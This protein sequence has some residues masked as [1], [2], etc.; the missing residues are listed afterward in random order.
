MQRTPSRHG[1]TL[2]EL[3]VV[4]SIIALLVA[5]LLP[6]L[7]Q[8]REAARGSVCM[9]NQ[10]QMLLA[11]HTMAADH[12]GH[13]MSCRP[14]WWGTIR[15]YTSPYSHTDTDPP[16]PEVHVCPTNARITEATVTPLDGIHTTYHYGRWADHNG[17]PFNQLTGNPRLLQVRLSD[18]ERPTD[19]PMFVEAGNMRSQV[20]SNWAKPNFHHAWEA[21]HL[22]WVH[23][24]RS[25]NLAM[26]DG[27]VE[28]SQLGNF[29]DWW[30]LYRDWE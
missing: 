28:R 25:M 16:S 2:V 13:L 30:G 29:S 21:A 10:R 11:V 18:V 3:L 22:D 17:Q 1:F 27:H 5:L 15:P 9:S 4:I 20:G 14:W 24:N 12:N 6:A 26:V 19:R 7:Q 8:A 23:P